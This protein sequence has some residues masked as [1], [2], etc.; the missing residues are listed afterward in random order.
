MRSC[1][2]AG[3]HVLAPRLNAVGTLAYC[4]WG[5]SD[6]RRGDTAVNIS[7]TSMLTESSP[8]TV[9][10]YPMRAGTSR[11]RDNMFNNSVVLTLDL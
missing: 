6:L 5:E 4:C 3:L 7:L 11:A 8:V 9:K 10:S 2:G 1:L